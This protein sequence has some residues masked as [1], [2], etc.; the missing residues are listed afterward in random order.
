MKLT[1]VQ[2]S[3]VQ[4]LAQ[5]IAPPVIADQLS[6]TRQ[7]VHEVMKR[8]TKLG[9]L[10]LPGDL[11]RGARVTT[12]PSRSASVLCWVLPDLGWWSDELSRIRRDESRGGIV[13][14]PG[15]RP[16]ES[17][18]GQAIRLVDWRHGPH[19]CV[20]GSL[21]VNPDG[22]GPTQRT[23][24][25]HRERQQVGSAQLD[26]GGVATADLPWLTIPVDMTTDE[27]VG[28]TLAVAWVLESRALLDVDMLRA[29]TIL[30]ISN[31]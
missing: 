12:Y 9:V 21:V 3:V 20:Q 27:R 7:G 14:P 18:T 5:G 8:L 10:R 26:R 6:M 4:L 15:D 16:V 23:V 17:W 29:T 25:V 13:P 30:E 28:L 22:A 11:P 19:W 2:D 24:V 1:D 31:E